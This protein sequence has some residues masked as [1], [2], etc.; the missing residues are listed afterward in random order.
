[1]PIFDTDNTQR[2]GYKCHGC[3]LALTSPV[4]SAII[5]SNSSFSSLGVP[6][7]YF[8]HP[9]NGE[10]KLGTLGVPFTLSGLLHK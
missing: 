7:S 2:L 10:R 6:K 4:Y 9:P 3:K 1:M 5:Q 8:I